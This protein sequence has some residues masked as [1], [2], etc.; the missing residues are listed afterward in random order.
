MNQLS[1]KHKKN[2]RLM[3]LVFSGFAIA[4]CAW[5][6]LFTIDIIVMRKDRSFLLVKLKPFNT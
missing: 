2:T 4:I 1:D 3:F 5:M 6:F